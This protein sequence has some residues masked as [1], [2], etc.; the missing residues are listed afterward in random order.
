MF[1]SFSLALRTST[2]DPGQLCWLVYRDLASSLF[3]SQK[4]RCVHTRSP[5]GPA[6]Y[7]DLG[8]ATETA[9]A[10]MKIFRYEHSS[11]DKRDETF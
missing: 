6:G 10:G 1:E 11:S 9:V 5:A 3:P 4:I 2:Y 7:R 8:F